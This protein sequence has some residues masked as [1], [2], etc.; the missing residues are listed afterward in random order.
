VFC[1]SERMEQGLEEIGILGRKENLSQKK[2]LE[3]N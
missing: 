1:W 2:T 3:E